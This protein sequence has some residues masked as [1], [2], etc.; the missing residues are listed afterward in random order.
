M[1]TLLAL[2]FAAATQAS[3]PIGEE[4]RTDGFY[5]AQ[6]AVPDVD[7]LER[8]WAV[9]G[10]GVNVTGTSELVRNKATFTTISFGGCTKDAAG[11]CRITVAYQIF[12][13]DGSYYGG[14]ESSERATAFDGPMSDPAQMYLGGAYMGVRIEPG[15]ALGK[16]RIRATTTDEIGHKTVVTER[17]LTA[18]EAK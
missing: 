11:R 13:P 6:L 9:P 15:E 10:E 14:R 7:G 4:G 2:V 17:V 16:Y 1:I 12:A 8:E 18:V 5:V 3:G